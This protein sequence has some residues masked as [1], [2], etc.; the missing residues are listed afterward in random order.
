[1]G[2]DDII[3]HLDGN[4]RDLAILTHREENPLATEVE[5]GDE[6]D[7]IC[8]YLLYHHAVSSTYALN[9]S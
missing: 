1:M 3:L 9:I 8:V 2:M 4:I 5:E 7:I 6:E